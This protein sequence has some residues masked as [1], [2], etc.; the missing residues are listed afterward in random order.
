MDLVLQ[1]GKQEGNESSYKMLFGGKIEGINSQ[2]DT[3]IDKEEEKCFDEASDKFENDLIHAEKVGAN[4]YQK[5]TYEIYKNSLENFTNSAT[6]SRYFK[7]NSIN[8]CHGIL[9]LKIFDQI[10]KRVKL[11]SHLPLP[12]NL[13]YML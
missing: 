7:R 12:S 6:N 3:M 10:S 1:K 2:L 4:N 9:V 13:A 8:V 11:A 5:Q